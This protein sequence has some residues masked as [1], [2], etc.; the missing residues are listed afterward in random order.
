MDI[1]CHRG[2]WENRLEQNSLTSLIAAHNNG[3]GVE[4][5]IRDYRSQIVISHDFP[6]DKSLP[7]ENYLCE[8]VAHEYN[9][10]TTLAINIKAD[11]LAKYLKKILKEY[12]VANYFT[13]DMSNP[14]L[15][16]YKKS[17]LN[18]FTRLSDYESHPVLGSDA[19]GLWLDSFENEWYSIDDLN[20]LVSSGKRLCIVSAELHGR[21]YTNQ[22]QLL[23]KL[24]HRKNMFLC[25]DEPNKAKGFFT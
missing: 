5:D 16:Q 18:F 7:F 3:F 11:G 13:F 22:W 19:M 14:E 15:L 9:N 24:K 10:D 25:T 6:N 21:R 2:M 17:G 20:M 4:L 12:K 1:I 23:K 8:L